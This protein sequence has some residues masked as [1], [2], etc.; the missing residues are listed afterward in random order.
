MEFRRV[1]FRS[2]DVQLLR[3]ILGGRIGLGDIERDPAL[4]QSIEDRFG[5]GSEAQA[6]F[7]ETAGDAETL[8]DSVDI[9]LETDEILE[10][11]AFLRKIGRAAC[12]ERVFSTCRSRWSP[13]H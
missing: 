10:R 2:P 13:Y 11:P 4:A 8:G 12:R 9:A 5:E 6:P 7:H 1:L 3:L